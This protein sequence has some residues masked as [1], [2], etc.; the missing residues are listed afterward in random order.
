MKQA[1][2]NLALVTLGARV[3]A[4]GGFDGKQRLRSV[5]VFRFFFNV[6]FAC[7]LALASYSWRL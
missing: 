6:F 1:R 3:Y 2:S 5:E 4:V 7:I